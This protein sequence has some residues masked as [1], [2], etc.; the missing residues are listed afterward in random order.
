MLRNLK[1][2]WVAA[3]YDSQTEFAK[4]VKISRQSL[5]DKVN[6]K[7][8]FTAKEVKRILDLLRSKGMVNANFDDVFLSDSPENGTLK[9][10][11]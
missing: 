7:T 6:E 9:K 3:G 4:D 5:S 1:I 8:D 11:A 2:A 10:G